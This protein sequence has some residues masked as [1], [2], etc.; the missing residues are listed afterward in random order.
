[1]KTKLPL[2]QSDVTYDPASRRVTLTPQKFDE[3]IKFIQE[4]LEQAQ[5]AENARDTARS[6]QR[7]Q[8]AAADVVTAYAQILEE[9][10][11]NVEAWL[12]ANSIQEL[13]RRTKIPYASCHRII[14][15]RLRSG[16]VEVGALG[17]I[18][19]AVQEGQPEMIQPAGDVAEQGK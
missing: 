10:N 14:R 1:M 3:L 5:T 19:Q 12:S 15:E 17:K 6:R 11:R 7:R 13:S 16:E 9:A 2:K 4:L 8:E 18:L